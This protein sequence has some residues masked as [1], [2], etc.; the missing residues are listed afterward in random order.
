MISMELLIIKHFQSF[1]RD[2]YFLKY[3]NNNINKFDKIYQKE[4]TK[5]ISKLQ[6][7]ICLTV[8]KIKIFIFYILFTQSY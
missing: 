1:L 5:F 6:L 8:G 3:Y 4:I 7:G 2:L